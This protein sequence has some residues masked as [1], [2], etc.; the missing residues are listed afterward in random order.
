MRY[1]ISVRLVLG[2]TLLAPAACD[3]A[4]APESGQGADRAFASTF[5]HLAG[6]NGG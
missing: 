4:M 2:L 5:P 6:P 1:P 3:D